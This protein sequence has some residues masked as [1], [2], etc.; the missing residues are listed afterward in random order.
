MALERVLQHRLLYEHSSSFA[1]AFE[2]LIR[3][4]SCS[5]LLG[6]D[7]KEI[8][9]WRLLEKQ[10]GALDRQVIVQASPVPA[11]WEDGQTMLATASYRNI[12]N[13]VQFNFTLCTTTRKT[14]KPE[15][16]ALQWSFKPTWREENDM[17]SAPSS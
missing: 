5:R 17:E 11:Y 10:E 14:A 15:L 4:S 9:T 16:A 2:W 6:A 12:A 3:Q 1:H 8:T 7:V 13:E